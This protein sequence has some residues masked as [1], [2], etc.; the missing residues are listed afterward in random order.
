MGRMP[1][2]MTKG[3]GTYYLSYDQVGSLRH[4]A[5][6]LG[7]LVKSIEYD[8]F[9]NVISDTNPSFELP[10]GFAGG[11][12]DSDTGLVRFGSRDYDPDT[13]R[14][15][16]KDPIFFEAGDTDLYGY[17]LN[18]PVSFVD[19]DGNQLQDEQVQVGSG[20]DSPSS[21]Y[22]LI[23]TP[24][25]TPSSPGKTDK[26]KRPVST[27]VSTEPSPQRRPKYAS[28]SISGPCQVVTLR[29]YGPVLLAEGQGSEAA[30]AA[31]CLSGDARAS[32]PWQP[33]G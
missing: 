1:A 32:R 21:I 17:C 26:K 2:I 18:N 27:P 23:F 3:A 15:T 19:P 16:G 14:W 11:L 29:R 8:S 33:S 31:A 24:I 30:F 12:Q 20:Y 22:D 25:F 5:D 10:L 9:G 28:S 13:G 6:S 4:V 7:T